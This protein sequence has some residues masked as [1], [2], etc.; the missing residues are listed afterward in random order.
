MDGSDRKI[1]GL[2]KENS[3]ISVSKISRLDS[4]RDGVLQ[5][6]TAQDICAGLLYYPCTPP[7]AWEITLW[8]LHIV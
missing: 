1:L 7:V 4:L 8:E 5:K 6:D 3:N 2:M